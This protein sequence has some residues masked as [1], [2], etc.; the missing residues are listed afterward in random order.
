MGPTP[1]SHRLRRGLPGYLIPFAPHAFVHSASGVSQEAAFA[2]GVP[3]DLYAFHRYTGN[4]A[5]LSHPRAEQYRT[6]S[7][8]CARGFHVRLAQPPTHALRPVNPDNARL[9]RF[10]AAAGT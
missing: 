3:P 7:P 9:L 4:S 10:T 8:S 1:S 5:S 2:T 6:A